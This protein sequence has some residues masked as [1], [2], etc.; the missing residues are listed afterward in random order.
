MKCIRRATKDDADE[1]S[2]LRLAAYAR[3]KEF[4]LENPEAL[5]WGPHDDS[6]VVLAAW[7]ESG[8]AIST[9]RGSI[10]KD[11]QE[12]EEW[13]TCSVD[14]DSSAFPVLLLGK[15][16]TR[17]EYGRTG[18]HSALRYYCLA[19]VLNTPINSVLGM[20][21]KGAPRTNL[22]QTLGYRFLT[23]DRV[24]DPEGVP[25]TPVMVAV[26][27]RASIGYACEILSKTVNPILM[28]YPWRGAP[29]RF[30]F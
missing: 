1:I 5:R 12:A 27:D 6:D 15:A 9:T 11:R 24:W 29:L 21:Y 20:V 3:A 30:D 2:S 4:R 19:A 13:L 18:L 25:L 16:A 14:L 28:E 8:N 17:E 23:P 22:M 7:D 10:A 26:L